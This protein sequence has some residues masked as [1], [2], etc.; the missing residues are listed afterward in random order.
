MPLI[1][2]FFLLFHL[3]SQSNTFVVPISNFIINNIESLLL[4]AHSDNYDLLQNINAENIIEN[5]NYNTKNQTIT[6]NKNN[7]DT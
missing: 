2:T 7:K 4:S 1:I 3:Y 5:K 6:I